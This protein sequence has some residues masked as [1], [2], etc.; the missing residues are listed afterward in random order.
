[1]GP[2]ERTWRPDHPL[3]LPLILGRL[4]R[5]P[6][7]PTTDWHAG[8]WWR[9][10]RTPAGLA[11][12]NLAA[13]PALGEVHARA[14]GDGATWALDQLPALLGAHDN[15]DDLT[16]PP[17]PLREA[18]RRHP[19]LRL[20]A[21]GLVTESLIAAILEQKVT[22]REAHRA[23][24]T[25]VRAYGIPAPGPHS[26]LRVA[27]AARDW[28]RIP[29]WDWHKA[30]VDPKRADTIQRAVRLAPRLEQAAAMTSAEA[31]ARLTTVPGIG[32]WTAA[33]TLQ[34]SNGDPDAVSVGDFHL[35]NAVG[36]ALAGRP[37]STDEEMLELLAPYQGH[38]HRVCRLITLT[39]ARPPRFGP[40]LAPEDHR[41]R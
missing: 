1:M 27:P 39:G 19:G 7:D 12:L 11:T 3:D 9:A 38:R 10:S 4:R 34:R 24:A 33:E 2:L 21:T 36:M 16:L 13:R 32:H 37:R 18:Q 20:G 8:T 14:W 30:G 26:D 29:S 41:R 40:R 28:A 23:Y 17:G 22:V 6:A 35:K 31:F 5:G 15:P 25:L